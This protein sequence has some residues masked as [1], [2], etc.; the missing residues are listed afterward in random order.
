MGLWVTMA[1]ALLVVG[2]LGWCLVRRGRT[3]A[4]WDGREPGQ[5]KKR[6]MGGGWIPD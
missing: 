5:Q 3:S 2:V 6:D 1:V 4:S